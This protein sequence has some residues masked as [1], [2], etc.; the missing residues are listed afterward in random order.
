M[1]IELLRAYIP[2]EFSRNGHKCDTS[3]ADELLRRFR[4]DARRELEAGHPTLR[5]IAEGATNAPPSDDREPSYS[6]LSPTPGETH[7]TPISPPPGERYREGVPCTRTHM[8][9]N[10]HPTQARSLNTSQP[11]PPVIPA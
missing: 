3:K 9:T 1:L 10:R 5:K 7:T 6:N 4:E 8:P 11:R 2:E